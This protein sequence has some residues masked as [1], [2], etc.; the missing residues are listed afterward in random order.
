MNLEMLME[1]YYGVL[2]NFGEIIMTW[3]DI[4]K[5]TIRYENDAEEFYRKTLTDM[6]TLPDKQVQSDFEY[7]LSKISQQKGGTPLTYDDVNNAKIMV[8]KTGYNR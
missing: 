3:K 6:Q 7:E 5:N 4:I 8:S 2:F 1:A